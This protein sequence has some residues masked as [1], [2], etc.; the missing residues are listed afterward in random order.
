MRLVVGVDGGSTKTVAVV[1]GL[2]GALL[3]IGRGGNSNRE[4]IGVERA[5]RIVS[6]VT[7]EALAMAG[8]FDGLE[9][10][11]R[12]S[13]FAGE[14]EN[15][16]TTYIEKLIKYGNRIQQEAQSAQQSLFGG[17]E[18]TQVIRKPEI[19][20]VDEWAKLILLEK[21]KNLIGIYLTAHPLDDYKLELNNFC[22]YQHQYQHL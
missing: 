2:D 12:S 20:R 16:N 9:G 8:A 10:I 3:G 18:N 19:P 21:E 11:K 4:V 17:M 5:A 22:K 6:E 14:N 13:F 1:C 7:R 15:D